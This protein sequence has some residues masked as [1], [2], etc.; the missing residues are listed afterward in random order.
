MYPSSD[1]L[2]FRT[3]LVTNTSITVLGKA[4]K[5]AGVIAPFNVGCRGDTHSCCWWVIYYY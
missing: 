2:C 1:C 3:R 5:S 4:F